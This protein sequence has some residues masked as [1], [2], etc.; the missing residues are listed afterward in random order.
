PDR[1]RRGL[2]A[3]AS[4][5]RGREQRAHDAPREAAFGLAFVD[6]SEPSGSTRRPIRPSQPS[7]HA[8]AFTRRCGH[9]AR[10]LTNRL[11]MGF[12]KPCTIV[13][14]TATHGLPKRRRMEMRFL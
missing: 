5:G 12:P 6:R 2:D 13:T 11:A 8:R 1:E 3:D 9:A 4:D 7:R 14:R 10:G